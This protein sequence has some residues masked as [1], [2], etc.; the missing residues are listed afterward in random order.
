MSESL[1]LCS[2]CKAGYVKPTGEVLVE[3]ESVGEFKDIGGRSRRVY[4]CENCRQRQIRIGVREYIAIGD[5]VK[6]ETEKR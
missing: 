5:E 3:G 1:D 4:V 6:T 2:T